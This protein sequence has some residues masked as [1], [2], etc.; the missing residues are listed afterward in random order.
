MTYTPDDLCVTSGSVIAALN[1][2]TPPAV[3]GKYLKKATLCS[4]MSPAIQLDDVE[5]SK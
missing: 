3:K 1:N 2:A 4:T 5:L